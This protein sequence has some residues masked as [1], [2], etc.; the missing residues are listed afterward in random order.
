MAAIR[1]IFSFGDVSQILIKES[2]MLVT[3]T[4]WVIG[5]VIFFYVFFNAK[6]CQDC[7][8]DPIY[9]LLVEYNQQKKCLP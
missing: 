4:Y 3:Y 7:P 6:M 1:R 9:T 2:F 5:K 8:D